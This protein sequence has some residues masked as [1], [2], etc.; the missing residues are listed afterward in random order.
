M[1]SRIGVYICHCGINIGATVDVREVAA[2]AGSLPHV[3]VARDYMYMCSDPGQEMIQQDVR[4][5]DLN[6]VVVASCSPRMH[7]TTFRTVIEEVGVNPYY[8]EM[9]NIR[10]QVSWV[11]STR[12]IATAKAKEL[13]AGTVAKASLLE[14]LEER[15]VA[16]TPAAVVIGGG[17]AGL[18]AALEIADAGYKAYLVE[19]QPSLGGRMAQLNKTFPRM[20]DAG[21]LVVSEMQRAMEHPNVEVLA[22]SEVVDVEGYIGNFQVKVRRKPR[23]VDAAKCTACGKCAEACVLAGQIAD[24]FQLGMAKRA[25]IYQAF[26]EGLPATYTVDPAHCLLIQ[27]GECQA[28]PP[29]A[30]ACPENAVDFDQQETESTLQ[31]GAIVVATGYDPFE[32]GRKPEF[33]Y[34]QYQGVITALEFERLAA[35]N[36]PTGGQILIPGTQKAP[37]HVVFVHC[38]GSRDK[39]IGNEYCSRVC[40]MY[41]AKQANVVLDQL[42]DSRVT[43]FYM[44]VRAFTKGGEEFYDRA[45]A[46]GA[47]YRRG[48]PSEIFWRGDKLVIRAEDT[49]LRRTVEVEADMAVLA[50]G[51]EP[52]A[53]GQGVAQMLKLSRTGDGFLA[54]AHPKLR[55]VDTTSD[56]IFLAGTCQGP[57]DIPDTVAQAKAAASSALIPLSMGKAKVEA[58][59]SSVDQ[60][61]C[62]GCG[63]CEAAC[64]YGALSM[65]PWRGIMTVNEVLCKGCGTCSVACPSKAIKLGHFT[66]K[67]TLAM[68]D[69]ILSL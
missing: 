19:R 68:L 64:T 61:L 26:P 56:G 24:E 21:A 43:V 23:F 62:V 45:R 14:P 4:D 39:Q 44:D 48:N 47:R 5:Y 59:V 22:Y 27:E 31:V 37:E 51:L 52:G 12:Q 16:V 65:H 17:I 69:A 13:V 67:Q 32:A 63:L 10:E 49:L 53:A 50:V 35:A 1:A 38:V 34:G 9:A 66:Q 30:L 60:E 36:G 41:T 8:F 33:G 25:A 58:I 57:K 54:E 28:G 3:V 42:P 46:R 2:Y 18:E 40:C 15:E 55:P 6:R 11:H 7:E 29:C 20:E